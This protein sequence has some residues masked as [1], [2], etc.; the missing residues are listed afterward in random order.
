MTDFQPE[1]GVTFTDVLFRGGWRGKEK[2]LILT[3]ALGAV[4]ALGASVATPM[5]LKYADQSVSAAQGVEYS[6][7]GYRVLFPGEPTVTSSTVPGASVKATLAQWSNKQKEYG[8]YSLPEVG[9]S[10]TVQSILQAAVAASGATVVES[11]PVAV[12][13]GSA[14][15][16]RMTMNGSGAWAL[17][18]ITDDRSY[19][20]GLLQTGEQRDDAFFDSLELK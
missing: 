7:D 11:H 14:L 9:E 16:A 12:K 15:A 5:L 4:V 18:V 20:L 10:A 1:K 8:A 6:G 17:M 13:G 3:L 2:K 19:G